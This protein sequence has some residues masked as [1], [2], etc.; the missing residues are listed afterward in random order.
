MALEKELVSSKSFLE[1]G[2]HEGI[3]GA[4]LGENAE[5]NPEEAEVDDEGPQDQ[6]TGACHEVRIEIVL[7]TGLTHIPLEQLVKTLTIV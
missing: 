5:V 3:T 1:R 7:P 2:A 4:G 6:S